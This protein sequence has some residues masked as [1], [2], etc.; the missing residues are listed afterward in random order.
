[1]ISLDEALAAY[2]DL[3]ALGTETVDLQAALGRRLAAA[4][5][6]PVDLPLADQSA[7]DGYALRAADA[8][9][10]SASR[11]I[12]LPLSGHVAAGDPPDQR[13][14]TGSACRIFTGAWLPGS[15]DCMVAQE[16]VS[17]TR[18][19][20]TLKSAPQPGQN[21]RRRG[22]ELS[23][24]AE[25]AGAH[26]EVTAGLIGALAMC[27]ISH[28]SCYRQ[29]RIALLVTGQ[30]LRPPGTVLGAGA[31]YDCNGPMLAA[32]LQDWGLSLSAI[33][34]PG[35]DLAETT[36][37][38]R[39]AAR[40]C[41]LTITTGG[42]SVG[43]HDHVKAAAEAVG[44]QTHYWRVAQKPGKPLYL[45]QSD[46]KLLLGLP[47]N[48]AAVFVCAHVHLR[49]IIRKLQ[50]ATTPRAWLTGRLLQELHP[51]RQ[52]LRLVRVTAK[53]G[54]HG[55]I[56]LDSPKN[57]A[58]HMLSNLALANGIARIPPSEEAI[59]EGSAVQ[60]LPTANQFSLATN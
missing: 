52:R 1:M 32:L 19:A 39:E 13:I 50:G 25:I 41:D 15:L 43:A 21:I 54:S 12:T 28:L 35:D 30:E 26:S 33:Y 3:P 27:G 56:Q 44:Y 45:G 34:Y 7:L 2:G 17:A 9:G 57:Q 24:G 46:T 36:R 10:A 59:P 16:Q 58:S 48:P 49:E 23:A 55:K 40:S 60:W 37:N 42:V 8:A 20:V 14:P 5:H 29:P 31:A 18:T 11:P 47:G 6:S 22:E 51:D 53:F 4:V 38:L